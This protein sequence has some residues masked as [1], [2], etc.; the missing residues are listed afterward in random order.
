MLSLMYYFEKCLKLPNFTYY[1][2]EIINLLKK[3]SSSFW[4]GKP[5]LDLNYYWV[6]TDLCK[7]VPAAVL[8][9]MMFFYPSRTE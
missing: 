8:L 7:I 5:I 1:T 2:S 4:T 3:S 6:L 9:L